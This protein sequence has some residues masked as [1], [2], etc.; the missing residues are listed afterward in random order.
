MTRERVPWVRPIFEVDDGLFA[1]IRAA[2]AT[3]RVT[4]DGPVLREFEGRL[5]RYLA[6]DDCVVV[7]SG[8]AALILSTWLLGLSGSKAVVPS[9]TF[10]AT[11]NAMAHT[12]MTPVFCDID[13]DTWTMSPAHLTRLLADDPGIRLVVPVN[14]F[15]VPPD[16]TGIAR[17]LA[18]SRVTLLLDNAHGMGTQVNG[19]HCT[20]EPLIHTYSFH[21]TK[22]LPTVEGGAIVASDPQLLA[23]LRR[24]RNHGIAADP[25]TS[26]I[27]HNAKLS[28]LHAAVGLRSLQGLDAALERRRQYAERMRRGI[29]DHCAG[30]FTP[31]RVPA[32]VVSNFQNLGVRCRLAARCDVAA[33]QAELDRDG[34]ESRRYFWPP[35]HQ[36]PPYRGC[37]TL[38]VTDEVFR[39]MLCLP[40]HS[41][42]DESTLDRIESALRRCAATFAA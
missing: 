21:A 18:G 9:F 41:R 11:L 19:V 5:A 30:L 15:G 22:T 31:Q 25:L 1:D 4:N 37:C 39:S 40:L 17:A 2:L 24:L 36:L 42:M 26:S 38:P 3:G 33:I 34:I 27:G 6:V 14:V 20:S 28:E 23:E 7:S 32:G 29:A 12:G 8:T 16:L 35:L 13:P 10:I